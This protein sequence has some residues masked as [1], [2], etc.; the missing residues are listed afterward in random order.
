MIDFA[1]IMFR[2][3]GLDINVDRAEDVLL[4]Q[5]LLA[6]AKDPENQPVFHIRFLE[7]HLLSF[8]T[9]KEASFL[10]WSFGRRIERKI[11]L[12]AQ[13]QCSLWIMNFKLLHIIQSITF[14]DKDLI[15]KGL[16]VWKDIANE[17]EVI[18]G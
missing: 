3:Y 10:R 15:N 6:R 17:F 1:V 4:H 12:F 16:D 18:I 9:R 2:S 8:D 11:A 13:N 14:P 5:K 7:V